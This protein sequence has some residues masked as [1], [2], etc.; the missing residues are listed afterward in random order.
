MKIAIIGGGASGIAAALSAADENPSAHITILERLDAVGKKILATGNGHCNMTNENISAEHYHSENITA[1]KKLLSEMPTEKV[2]SFFENMGL[3]T[4]TDDAGRIYPYCRQASMVLDILL[5]ELERKKINVV[6]GFKAEYIEFSKNKFTI[7][8]QWG[9]IFRADKVIISAGGKAA[10]KQGT[11][12]GGY[13]LAK[14]L[15]HTYTYIFPSLVAMECDDKVFK[16]FK[17]IRVMGGLALFINGEKK[18][19]DVGEI[20]LTD[21]GVSGIPAM[22]LSCLLKKHAIEKQAEIGIDFFPD[23]TAVELEEIITS[24]IKK[25]PNETLE[26][27]FL[28]LLNKKIMYALLERSGAY[29]LSRKANSLTEEEVKETVF[30]LKMWKF[31]V[32]GTTG[33][34]FAQVTG[35]GI[36]LDEIDENFQSKIIP[37]L[38]FTGEILDVTGECGGYNLHWAWCSGIKAGKN[39]AKDQNR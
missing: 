26:N 15:G 24:K 20:Q 32:K 27:L 9:D 38:Y 25:Y 7:T 23:K 8:S 30:L 34:D 17:G 39:A 19:C 3:Y 35:G 33:W 13:R 1:A 11:D 12:G 22:Q 6:C 2:L 14:K 21:Y 5:A 31:G 16:G 37:N 18:T 29:P 36:P 10:P 28:G 4:M